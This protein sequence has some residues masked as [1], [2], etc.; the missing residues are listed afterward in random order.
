MTATRPQRPDPPVGVWYSTIVFP[1]GHA[2]HSILR[3]SAD[4]GIAESSTRY[5]TWLNGIGEWHPTGAGCFAG[6]F[7]KF[8]FP[9]GQ[10]TAAAWVRVEFEAALNDAETE[11]TADARGLFM[12]L[13]RDVKHMVPTTVTARR[14]PWKLDNEHAA[15]ASESV[16]QR[17]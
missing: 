16:A 6:Y 4:G 10:T 8:A 3:Y 17:G 11:Y 15:Q 12:D 5:P 13:D 2:E 14:V 9:A 7:E 1:D